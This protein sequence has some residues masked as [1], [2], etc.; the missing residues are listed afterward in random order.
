ML[1]LVNRNRNAAP[2][3]AP[4]APAAPARPAV[5][6]PPKAAPPT[7]GRLELRCP[8]LPN[9][10]LEALELIDHPERLEVRPVAGMVERDPLVV[11]RLLQTVNSAYYGL[12]RKVSSVDRAVVLLGPVAVAGIVVSMSML[13]LRSVLEGP[14]AAIFNR[15]ILHSTASAFLTRHITGSVLSSAERV[16]AS[17]SRFGLSLTAGLLHDFGK[18]ILVYNFPK[19]AAALYDE[20]GVQAHV[21]AEDEREMERLLFGYDHTEAGEY[22][23][24]KL[25]FPDALAEVMRRHHDPGAPNPDPSLRRLIMAAAGANVAAKA[26]GYHIKVAEGWE[27]LERDPV[28]AVLASE[29]GAPFDSA[30]AVVAHVQEQTEQVAEYVQRMSEPPTQPAAGSGPAVMHQMYGRRPR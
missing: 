17:A 12:Q 4:A 16:G 3:P 7:L 1:S 27:T 28:W 10:L 22:A 19:E 2:A 5:G 9:T 15:L 18:I 6:A 23:A 29:A 14:A 11:A 24:W 13:R 25:N 26:M 8:P 30:A 20:N 21:V